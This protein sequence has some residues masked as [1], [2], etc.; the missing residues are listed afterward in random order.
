MVDVDRLG[1]CHADTVIATPVATEPSA[2]VRADVAV[3]GA[4]AAGI[5]A[6]LSAARAGAEVVLISRSPLAASASYWAQGGVAAALDASDS[7]ADHVADTMRAGRGLCA[8]KRCR[9]ALLRGA[10]AGA[11]PDRARRQVRRRPDR[12]ACPRARRRSQRAARG[13][14]RRQRDRTANHAPALRA[15]RD[16]PAR[17]RPRGRLGRG[18]VGDGRALRRP[19]L[20][21]RTGRLPTLSERGAGLGD[22]PGDRRERRPCGGGRQTRAERSAP[23]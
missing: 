16:P 18:A 11:R 10:G 14:R 13:A 2:V 4:G 17:A 23:G 7:V 9:G 20:R 21:A 8:R 6:A 12:S 15:R 3:V 1:R 5:Y 22:D 19:R